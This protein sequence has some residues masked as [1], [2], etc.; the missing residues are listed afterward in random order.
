MTTE[1]YKNKPDHS[2]DDELIA[3]LQQKMQSATT[4]KKFSLKDIL[5]LA[6]LVV[7]VVISGLQTIKLSS[8]QAATKSSS[9][10]PASNS[11]SPAGGSSLPASLQNLPSQVGGC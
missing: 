7:L 8:L 1:N 4:A 3:R 5:I 9:V 2:S 6:V 10:A 11:G